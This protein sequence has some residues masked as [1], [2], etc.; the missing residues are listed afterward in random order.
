MTSSRR[1]LEGEYFPP[2]VA[3]IVGVHF[4]VLAPIMWA[5]PLWIVGAALTRM[6]ARA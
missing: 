6:E 1:K 2:V 3:A 5:R 4:L